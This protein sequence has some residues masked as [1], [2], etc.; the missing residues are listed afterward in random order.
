MAKYDSADLLER[1]VRLSMRPTTDAQQTTADWYAFLTEAQ[2]E[3][4]AHFASI[5]PEVLY[6]DPVVLTSADGGYTYTF[7]L[8][9]AG[10]PI[11]P[12]GHVEL[13]TS[14]NGAVLLPTT[15]WG[16]VGDFLLEG[17]KIRWPNGAARSFGSEGPVARFITPP[18]VISAS[19]QPVLIPKAARMLLVHR[20][21][22][23]WARRGGM[24]DPQPFLDQEQ[25]LWLGNPE[26]GVMG[27]LGTLKTQANFS[28][29]AAV[30]DDG[31][32]WWRNINTGSGY[33]RAV[34]P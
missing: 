27:I 30:A 2:D 34:G 6:G 23:K 28:G 11:F 5:V 3:W 31:A 18:D 20:A 19:V 21:C 32:A 22:A 8:D 29:A 17:N 7:G 14:R 25:E 9:A 4:Y 15:D 24:R 12:I 13:R 16:N 33:G 1:C 26:A 10:D